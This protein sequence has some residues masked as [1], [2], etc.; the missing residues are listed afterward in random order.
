LD[1]AATATPHCGRFQDLYSS[2]VK[3]KV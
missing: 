1:T 3:T 2:T